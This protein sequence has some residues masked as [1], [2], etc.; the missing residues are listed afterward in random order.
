MSDL[1]ISVAPF[2]TGT[3]AEIDGH[4]IKGITKI[5]LTIEVGGTPTVEII[6]FETNEDGQ[7]IVQENECG[8]R[9]TKKRRFWLQGGTVQV[10]GASVELKLS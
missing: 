8:E 2:V 3:I 5:V 7:V 6:G 10:E 4:T 1:K 9:D